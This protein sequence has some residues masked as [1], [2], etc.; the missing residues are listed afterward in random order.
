MDTKETAAGSDG[1]LKVGI[2]RALLYYRYIPLWKKFFEAL[3]AEVIISG[4]TTKKTVDLGV[5]QTVDEACFPVKVYFGHVLELADQV[6]YLFI[7]R[8]VS[9]EKKAYIC[10]KFLGLPDMIRHGIKGLPKVLSPDVNLHRHRRDIWPSLWET[11]RPFTSNPLKVCRAYR[12]ALAEYHAYQNL[13]LQGFTPEQAQT[14][15]EGVNSNDPATAPT[16]ES[17]ERQSGQN[18][19]P[20][21]RLLVAIIGHPYNLYDRH[22]SM[23]ILEKLNSMGVRTVTPENLSRIVTDAQADRLPKRLFWTMGRNLVGAAFH[24]LENPRVDGIIHLAAFGC[25]PDSFTGEIIERAVRRQGTTAY[26]N[27]TIDEHT[28]EAGVLTRLEAFVDMLK[29]RTAGEQTQSNLS[30]YGESICRGAGCAGPTRS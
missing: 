26:L 21:R 9:V 15:L 13:L 14:V 30:S 12:Q 8:L 22:A 1:R 5:K 11:G 17:A 20:E 18:C 3:G 7:P 2:P 10:P 29:R 23:G 25:G 4:P 16:D 28:G 27:L 19:L 6:D 24:Y